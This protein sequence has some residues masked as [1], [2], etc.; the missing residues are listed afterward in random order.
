MTIVTNEDK[1]TSAKVKSWLSITD[2]GAIITLSVPTMVNGVQVD[3]VTLRS[4]TLAD[5]RQMDSLEPTD[6]N[7][8]EEAMFCSLGQMGS[9][10]LRGF[11]LKDY[12]R[13]QEG[14]FQLASP[15]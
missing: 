7:A 1:N 2:A 5:S 9:S 10:D 3:K 13:L 8:W 6:R 4:P 14:Y 15:D 12:Y 11:K